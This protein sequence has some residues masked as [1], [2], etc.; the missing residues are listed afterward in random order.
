MHPASPHSQVL[1]YL[2]GEDPP[3]SQSAAA[4]EGHQQSQGTQ[5]EDAFK[6][7]HQMVFSGVG[8]RLD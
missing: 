7:F 4:P 3:S 6:R 5:G 1:F 8:V 2:R